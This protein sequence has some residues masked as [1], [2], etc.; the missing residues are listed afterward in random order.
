ML[1]NKKIIHLFG[2]RSLNMLLI[3]ENELDRDKEM[4]SDNVVQTPLKSRESTA[5]TACQPFLED[6]RSD[7]KTSHQ[8]S[9]RSRSG[10]TIITRDM[11][12]RTI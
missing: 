1:N 10:V 3:L 4:M 5:I 11:S 12:L 9:L 8:L 7:S 6:F 2:I